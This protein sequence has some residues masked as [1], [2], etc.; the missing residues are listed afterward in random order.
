MRVYQ[1][2]RAFGQDLEVEGNMKT[3]IYLSDTYTWAEELEAT[4]A[5]TRTPP[6]IAYNELTSLPQALFW[7]IILA[8]IF[9]A[10]IILSSHEKRIETS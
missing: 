2:S 7:S 3:V 10:I 6:L 5:F 8:P 1:R 4:G 9:L